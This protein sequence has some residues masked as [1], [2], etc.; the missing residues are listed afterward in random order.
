[1]GQTIKIIHKMSLNSVFGKEGHTKFYHIVGCDIGILGL[2]MENV[3]NLFP[4]WTRILG[5]M[6]IQDCIC[7]GKTSWNFVGGDNN[8]IM[9]LEKGKFGRNQ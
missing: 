1:M 8:T 4:W 9:G 6:K 2:G 3:E 5:W 7:G